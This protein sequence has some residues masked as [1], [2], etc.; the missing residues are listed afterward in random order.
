LTYP[1]KEKLKKERKVIPLFT[2]AL[3]KTLAYAAG[4]ILLVAV[5][6]NMSSDYSNN[7]YNKLS[8]KILKSETPIPTEVFHNTNF[9]S[10]ELLEE[11]YISNLEYNNLSFEP[12]VEVSVFAQQPG[13]DKLSPLSKAL[14]LKPEKV[15]YASVEQEL[16]IPDSYISQGDKPEL[17]TPVTR[18]ALAIFQENTGRREKGGISLLDVADLGF[19]GINKLTGKDWEIKRFYNDEGELTK[20]ALKAESVSFSTNINK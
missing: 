19:Q 7:N 17:K 6:I 13:F 3:Q 11:T 5:Y 16:K 1:Q 18:Q 15:Q 2:N 14:T 9:V 20:L 8:N 10:D 4:V 12:K